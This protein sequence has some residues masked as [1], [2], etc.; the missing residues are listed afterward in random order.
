MVD[1]IVVSEYRSFDFTS[2][3]T[4]LGLDNL[5]REEGGNVLTVE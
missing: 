4:G 1:W 3:T 5:E 2:N